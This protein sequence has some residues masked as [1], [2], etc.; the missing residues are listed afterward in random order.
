MAVVRS[1][2][3]D[4]KRAFWGSIDRPRFAAESYL[5]Q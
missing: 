2:F 4:R 3:G 5:H 1:R